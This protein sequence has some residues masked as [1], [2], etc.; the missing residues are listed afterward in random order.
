M[1]SLTLIA[2]KAISLYITLSILTNIDYLM[3]VQLYE[4]KN[5][6]ILGKFALVMGSLHK[7]IDFA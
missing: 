7:N 5:S 1:I 4:M 6:Q 3:F 2:Q